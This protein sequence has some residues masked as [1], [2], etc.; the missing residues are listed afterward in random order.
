MKKLLPLLAV[1]AC[2][3]LFTACM[4]PNYTRLIPENKDAEIW[5]TTLYGTIH[6]STRVNPTGTNGLGA[7]PNTTT[8][9]PVNGILLTK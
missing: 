5:V 1:A 6:V 2:A 3:G 4:S 7:L 9:T 8:A